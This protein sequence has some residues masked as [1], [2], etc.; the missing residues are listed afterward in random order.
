MKK[1]LS[2]SLT[3]LTNAQLAVLPDTM[4]RI[5]EIL[6]DIRRNKGV[7]VSYHID[8]MDGQYVG[9]IQFCQMMLRQITQLCAQPMDFH[10]MTQNFYPYATIIDDVCKNSLSAVYK[11]TTHLDTNTTVTVQSEQTNR[12]GIAVNPDESVPSSLLSSVNHVVLMTV[13]P[14]KG[15]QQ[16]INQ[17]SKLDFL[18]NYRAKNNLDY[19][20]V[21]D[22]GINVDTVEHVKLADTIVVGSY[23]TRALADNRA[24]YAIDKLLENWL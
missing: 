17:E 23:F 1:E 5:N 6:F 18:Y 21:V 9:N 20:I 8:I 24:E 16:F 15:G 10:L 11:I 12:F 7:K 13:C 22:G 19:T 2:I 3:G 14:G 4:A